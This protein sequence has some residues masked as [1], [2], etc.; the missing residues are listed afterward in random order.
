MKNYINLVITILHIK[1]KII[2][3]ILE[4]LMINYQHRTSSGYLVGKRLK[5]FQ[6]PDHK[7]I[8]DT[9]KEHG[10]FFAKIIKVNKVKYI[11]IYSIL[12]MKMI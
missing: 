8:K 5:N 10:G 12:T 6:L 3:F 9:I 11:L 1:R 2:F 4:C 7:I